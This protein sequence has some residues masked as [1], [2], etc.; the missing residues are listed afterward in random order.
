M[1]F[2]LLAAR[3][4]LSS[5]TLSGQLMLSWHLATIV[6]CLFV[7]LPS[8]GQMRCHLTISAMI[9]STMTQSQPTADSVTSTHNYTTRVLSSAL[10]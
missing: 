4:L 6:S 5:F 7:S 3:L 9:M 1:A 2:V 10:S 8:V